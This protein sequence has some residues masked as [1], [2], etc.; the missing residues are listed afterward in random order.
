MFSSIGLVHKPLDNF[1]QSLKL[2]K[3]N[4]HRTYD[5]RKAFSS[6]KAESEYYGFRTRNYS[7]TYNHNLDHSITFGFEYE[8][9]EMKYENFI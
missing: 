4:H 7:G 8:N 6:S 5:Q 1:T 2:A 9:D 3:S